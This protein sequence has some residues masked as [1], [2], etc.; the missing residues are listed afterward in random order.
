VLG[1]N[2]IMHDPEDVLAAANLFRNGNSVAVQSLRASVRK[3]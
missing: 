1:W 3:P 2:P